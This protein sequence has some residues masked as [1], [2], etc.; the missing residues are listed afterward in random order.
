MAIGDGFI[1]YIDEFGWGIGIGMGWINWILKVLEQMERGT[2]SINLIA[3][4]KSHPY[5]DE[6]PEVKELLESIIGA[7]PE[8]VQKQTS[9]LIQQQSKEIGLKQISS[10]TI[11]K[12]DSLKRA[13]SKKKKEEKE[14]EKEN[15][16]GKEEKLELKT[17]TPT[18]MAKVEP[19]PAEQRKAQ[20]RRKGLQVEER[21]WHSVEVGIGNGLWGIIPLKRVFIL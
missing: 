15:E 18:A 7:Q 19:T 12:K 20:F 10:K 3:R 8:A 6:R 21:R 14:K 11:A 4:I 5:Y 9:K 17:K 2:V 1:E 16:E 13:D